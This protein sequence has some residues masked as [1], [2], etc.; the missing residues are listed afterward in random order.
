M[1]ATEI[2]VLVVAIAAII[3]VVGS[4]ALVAGRKRVGPPTTPSVDS[5][6]PDAALT[7]SPDQPLI[8]ESSAPGASTTTLER[9]ESIASRLVRLR[10]RLSG[11]GALGRGLLLLLSR[12]PLDEDT[13]EAVEDSLITADIGV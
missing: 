10:Q 11:Q 8:V 12:D 4:I 9:P 1:T 2:I 5:G 3:L 7:P 6:A 13:W